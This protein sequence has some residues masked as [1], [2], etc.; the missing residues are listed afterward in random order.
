MRPSIV[1]NVSESVAPA[2]PSSRA[3]IEIYGMT[4][5]TALASCMPFASRSSILTVEVC[6]RSSPMRIAA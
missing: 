5:F 3:S 6:P 4:R 2:I 1:W